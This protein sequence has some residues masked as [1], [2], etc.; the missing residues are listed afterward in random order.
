MVIKV[1]RGVFE[2]NS[3]STHSLTICSRKEY[4]AWKR[5]DLVYDN[6]NEELISIDALS[7]E[8]KSLID[9]ERFYTVEGYYDECCCD[10]ETFE[11][12]FTTEK[13][14]EI[15]TFGYYGYS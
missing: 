15:I 7:D 5:G 3:S 4:D 11:Q 13:G 9:E 6:Y 10:Y 12:N 8:D 2:T 14:E 1:R